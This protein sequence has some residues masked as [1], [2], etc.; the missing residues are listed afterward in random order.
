MP[1]NVLEIAPRA[2]T[3]PDEAAGLS[4]DKTV[5][6]LIQRAVRINV[7]IMGLTIGLGSGLALFFVTQLSL[8]ITGERAGHY[9]NLLGVF[10]PGYS[11]SPAG[12]WIGLLWGFVVGGASGA[13]GYLL[14]SRKVMKRFAEYTV[15]AETSGEII[16]RP[17]ATLSG[18]SLGLAFGLLVAVQLYLTTMWLV[19]SGRADSSPHAELLANYLPGYSVSLVGA[20]IGSVELFIFTYVF[21][22]IFTGIYNFIAIRRTRR[23]V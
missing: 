9:L 22:W 4:D 10:L 12:A 19:I 2:E 6:L 11:A 20:I 17:T 8:A 15:Q 23:S 16:D 14:Y 13:Y 1:N 3:M 18:Q 7:I 21:A 5:D